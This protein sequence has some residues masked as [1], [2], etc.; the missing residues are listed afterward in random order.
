MRK[1]H[2]LRI[3]TAVLAA[4]AVAGPLRA[5]GTASPAP[6]S[7]T[8]S[9]GP[10]QI[11]FPG[12][13]AAAPADWR[14]PVWPVGCG[15]FSGEEKTACL[16]FVALDYA[17]LSRYAEADQ[18][19]APKRRGETRVVFFGDSIT[20]NWSKA[21]FGGFFPGQAYVNRGIGGQ[22]TSQMLLRF[23]PDVVALDPDVVVILARTTWAGTGGRWRTRWSRAT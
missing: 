16:E 11:D 23:R 20:D 19:L 15:R 7:P 8:P 2:R 14:F 1:A 12:Q 17:R 22:T 5:S 4:L 21:G 13:Y 6:P 10:P 3:M 18:R 9:P